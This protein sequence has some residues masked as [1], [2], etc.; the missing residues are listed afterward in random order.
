MGYTEFG[1]SLTN[2]QAKKLAD[3]IR[4]K[5]IAS[6]KLRFNELNGEHKLPLTQ[7]Q[8]NKINKHKDKGVG[9]ILHLSQSQLKHMHKSGGVLPLLAILPAIF[10]G[11]AA[12]GGITG[13]VSSI[14]EAVNDKKAN[15]K[16]LE[17][18]Q[19]HNLE[20]EKQL[21]KGLHLNP[22]GSGIQNK[23]VKKKQ[24]NM[25]IQGGCSHCGKGCF[26]NPN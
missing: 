9:I 21:G 18:Q 26:L 8:I 1:V 13:G 23:N 14:A 25:E 16:M 7:M 12:A 20:V 6:L 17:E 10:G 2:I 15:N 3:A 24:K 19:R 5:T 11:L 22:M 4:T